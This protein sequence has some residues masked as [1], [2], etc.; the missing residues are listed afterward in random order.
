MSQPQSS[1]LK[2]GRV[3]WVTVAASSKD[4]HFSAET[5]E[6]SP[7]Q[8]GELRYDDQTIPEQVSTTSS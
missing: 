4:D 8:W 7:A 5:R 6:G 3:V 2:A 1:K